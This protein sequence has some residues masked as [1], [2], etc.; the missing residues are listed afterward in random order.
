M[1]G[2][3]I[4]QGK[5]M[6]GT[7]LFGRYA[8]C[9]GTVVVL[10]AVA[11]SH[12][13]SAESRPKPSLDQALMQARSALILAE[14]GFTG[15]GAAVLGRAVKE[16]R[17]VLLG[18]DHLSREIPQFTEKLCD[19]MKPDAFAVEAGPVAANF[20]TTLLGS[21]AR[22]ERMA[23]RM[24]AH[25]NN[26]AFLD[27]VEESDAAAHCAA[28]SGNPAFSIWGLDQEFVGSAGTLLEAM[29]ATDPGPMS[30]AAIGEL[31]KADKLTEKQAIESGDPGKLFLLSATAADLKPLVDAI[32]VDGNAEARTLL[33]EMLA[34][35]SIYRLNS[36]GSPDSNRVRAELFKQHFLSENAAIRKTITQPRILFKFGDNHSGK[37]FSPLQVLDIGNF[38]A[39]F[40]DGEKARSLHIMIFGVRGKHGVFAGVGKP[41]KAESFAIA[42]YPEYKWMDPVI[43]NLLPQAKQGAGTTLTLVDLRKLRFRGIDFPPD[44]KRIAYSYDLMILIPELSAATLIQ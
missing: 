24:R 17:Y 8:I 33:G 4:F 42:D 31:L 28:S 41:L 3:K 20:V 43:T 16:S 23:E 15:E 6:S 35:N 29:Q 27:G 39:E 26:M 7:P 22:K 11:A 30:R 9:L 14:G 44:W 37:G 10:V 34:S 38:V 40:A 13:W 2:L 21:T 18:E 19:M 25:P 36:E 32:E 5:V 12:A 1:Q